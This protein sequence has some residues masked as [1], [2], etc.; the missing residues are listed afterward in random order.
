[1]TKPSTKRCCSCQVFKPL[2]EFSMRTDRKNALKSTCKACVTAKTAKWKS[3]NQ[4]KVKAYGKRYY[5][6][7]IDKIAKK[8]GERYWQNRDAI[9]ERS[10]LSRIGKENC[11][12]AM[13]HSAKSR[14]KSNN[15]DFD[16]DLEYLASIATDHCPVDGLPFDWDRKLREDNTLSLAVPSLD[17]VDSSQGYVKGNVRIINNRW[18]S[19]KGNMSLDDLL[20]LVNYV[21]S[22]TKPE[23]SGGF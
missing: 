5:K 6:R 9:L 3:E 22:A 11:I 19:K 10:R 4:D 13:F 21:R 23:N 16:L 2:S 12:K 18:N 7:N 8:R 17:R 20:L 14:A 1:M 15:L